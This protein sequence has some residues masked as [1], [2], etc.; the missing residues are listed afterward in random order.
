MYKLLIVAHIDCESSNGVWNEFVQKFVT[1]VS[2]QSNFRLIY[3]LRVL[4]LDP[5]SAAFNLQL[6]GSELF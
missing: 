3:L 6:K 5:L 2:K 4:K 1:L